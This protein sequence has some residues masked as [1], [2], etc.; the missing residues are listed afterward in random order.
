MGMPV[1]ITPVFAAGGYDLV[2]ALFIA[3]GRHRR[4]GGVALGAAT[5]GIAGRHDAG[6]GGH[7]VLGAVPVQR[8]TIYPEVPAALA[9]AVALPLALRPTPDRAPWH[10]WSSAC[11]PRRCPG[12]AR[13][14]HRCRRPLAVAVAR[15]WWPMHAASRATALGVAVP[16]VRPYAVGLPAGSH[17][18]TPTGA[19]RGRSA[20]YGRMSQTE[21][22]NTVFGVP[23]LL[24]DQEYGLLAYAPAYVLAGFGFWTMVRR[25]GAAAPARAGDGADLRRADLHRRRLPHL[26]GRLGGARTAADLGAAGAAAADGGA[27]RL[28][29][30][31]RRRGAPR[32]IC[33]CGSASRVADAVRRRRRLAGEQRPRRHVVAPRVAVAALAAVDT[34]PTFIAHEAPRA[35]VDVA[36]WL[37]ALA[38]G[39]WMLGRVRARRAAARRWPR[40]PARRPCDRWRGEHAGAA[41]GGTPLPGIDLA[42]GPALAALDTFDHVTRPLALRYAPLRVLGAAG[43]ADAGRRRLGRAAHRAAAAARAAQRPFSLPAGHYR[44]VVTW[45]ARDPLPAAPGSRPAC[46]S[47]A[48]ARRYGSGRSPRA[49]AARGR[50]SSGCRSTP[51]SSASAARPSS[52]DPSTSCASRRSTWSTPAPGRHTP[53]VLA[54]PRLRADHRAVPRRADLPGDDRLLDHRRAAGAGHHRAARAAAAA[55]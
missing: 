25:P 23:G 50:T 11:W 12:S 47:A 13:S 1:L 22:A 35:M 24:F 49:R 52:S 32:S 17:S 9:V 4:D 39:S 27:D 30:R 33:S 45:A 31:R 28:G 16:V 20:P 5:T 40:S 38:L 43:R 48:S 29:A 53:Q 46:R 34:A 44:V 36:V 2:V 51:A 10:G 26:V 3:D 42:P 15:R 19:R 7:R 55:A 6:L 14:T 37:A 18:S 54:R 41:G 8:F 21:M